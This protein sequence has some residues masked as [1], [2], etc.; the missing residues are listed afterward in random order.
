MGWDSESFE[1]KNSVFKDERKAAI[2]TCQENKFVRCA[3]CDKIISVVSMTL[4]EIEQN[5]YCSECYSRKII[6]MAV[7]R[8]HNDLKQ[9]KAANRK[10]KKEALKP[11]MH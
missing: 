8:D 5:N 3:E 6:S 1:P 7:E 10:V 9:E 11:Q 4:Y 2:K